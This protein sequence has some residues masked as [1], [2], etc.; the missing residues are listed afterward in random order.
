VLVT[1]ELV[2]A[3]LC[4]NQVVF[5]RILHETGIVLRVQYCP[6]PDLVRNNRGNCHV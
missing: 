6:D 1:T 2:S 4:A 5:D 3:P